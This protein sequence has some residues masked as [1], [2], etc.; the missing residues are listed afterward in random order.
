MWEW[1][2]LIFFELFMWIDQKVQNPEQCEILAWEIYFLVF[3]LI[4][5][6]T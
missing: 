5:S 3:V 1:K 6:A 4:F 2:I